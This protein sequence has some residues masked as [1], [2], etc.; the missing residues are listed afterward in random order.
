MGAAIASRMPARRF[1]G[2]FKSGPALSGA[3]SQGCRDLA[4]LIIAA[5]RSRGFAARVVSG[6]VHLADDDDDD[7]VGGNVHAWATRYVVRISVGSFGHERR[8]EGQDDQLGRCA[9]SRRRKRK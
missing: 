6:F 8:G 7:F 4:V 1:Y 2:L 3:R 5:L 9:T